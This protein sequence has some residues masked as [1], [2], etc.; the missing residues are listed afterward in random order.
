VGGQHQSFLIFWF[1]FIKKKNKKQKEII[2]K[3]FLF[4]RLKKKKSC[5]GYK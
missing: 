1:F 2:G 5:K 4:I 3:T